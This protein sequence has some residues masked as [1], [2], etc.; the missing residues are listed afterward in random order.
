MSQLLDQIWQILR[1]EYERFANNSVSTIDVSDH[2]PVAI[3]DSPAAPVNLN[4]AMTTDTSELQ[5]QPRGLVAAYAGQVSGY[6]ELLGANGVVQE[7]WRP[8]V[9]FVQTIGPQRGDQL[10]DRIQRRIVENGLTL[11]SY[12]DPTNATQPWKLDL[13][14]LIVSREDWQFIERGVKQRALLFEHLLADLYGEQRCLA[15]G[16]IPPALIHA[17]PAYLNQLHGIGAEHSHLT[18]F[19]VDL[20][21]DRNGAWRVI[22]N[23]AETLAGHGYA[24]AN[25]VVLA[26][27]AA[28]LFRTCNALRISYFFKAVGDHLAQLSGVEDPTIAVLGPNPDDETYLSHA[29]IARYFG[30]PLLEGLDLRVV[31]EK[32]FL[33]TLSGLQ[34]V[35][36]LVRAVQASKCDPLE[37]DPDGYAGPAGLVHALRQKP[38]LVVNALGTAII[39][40]RG[41][42]PFLPNLAQKILLEDLLIADAPRFWL[43][44]EVV[45]QSVI[46]DP[47]NY[48]IR[49]AFEGT[50]RPGHA[51]Q[52][53]K[54]N[55]TDPAQS[56]ALLNE[57]HL[58]GVQ[59]VAEKPSTFSTAPSWTAAGLAPKPYA[60]RVFAAKIDNEFVVMPGGLALNVDV[61]NAVALTSRASESRD[62][63]VLSDEKQGP[64]YSRWRISDEQTQSF[65]GNLPSRLADNLYWLGRNVER[66][67]W[68]LRVMRS[69]LNLGDEELRS[70]RRADSASQAL[71][72]LLNFEEP[73]HE[74]AHDHSTPI[75]DRVS[76]LLYSPE[77]P[78]SVNTTFQHIHRLVQQTRN[79]LS[80]D[81]SR[82]LNSLR[83]HRDPATPVQDSID[84]LHEILNRHLSSLSAFNGMS[85]ENMTRNFGWRFLDIGRRIERSLQL[86]KLLQALLVKPPGESEETDRLV[87]LLETTDSF[88][89]YRARYRFAPSFPLVLDLLMIDE[90][91]PRSLAFQLVS[92]QEH[93][94]ALP[95]AAD[96]AMREPEQRIALDLLSKVQLSDPAAMRQAAE[97]GH[98]KKLDDLLEAM[99]KGLP[100]L[101]D[102]LSSRYFSHTD[103]DRLH[104]VHT[105]LIP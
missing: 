101:S 89:T 20:A 61:D 13:I 51:A 98:R 105:R 50:A 73:V 22:D 23:H 82:L 30:Y 102:T 95:R 84:D 12:S 3:E 77:L 24:L 74:L 44:D 26:D 36:G 85:H 69:A 14:P 31:G 32:I 96:D 56:K 87:Y 11:D 35:D 78:Y 93:I 29:Y 7:H 76:S 9:D 103:K 94:T 104:R 18:F 88:M 83:A 27:V 41:L 99:N 28:Q 71:T 86:S 100:E 40:N 1:N 5:A 70:I 53:K 90:K 15:D 25:R 43:G 37:L 39:E 55:G 33:K 62:V 2:R 21:K 16:S 57:L 58:N 17:D 67:D 81:A 49:R 65:G 68:T 91:N 79:R 8:V 59:Y 48:V 45:R 4:E 72:V 19:A 64:H 46:S 75:E 34:A 80:I 38:N 47:D 60:L 66:A 54:L 52:G 63:W 97:D 10:Y 42:A 6:D 92:I